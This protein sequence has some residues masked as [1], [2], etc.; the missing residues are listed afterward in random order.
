MFDMAGPSILL[1]EKPFVS[2]YASP[3]LL[4]GTTRRL[5]S[6]AGAGARTTTAGLGVFAADAAQAQESCYDCQ[7]DEFL[8]SSTIL[9]KSEQT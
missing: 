1:P 7:N 4:S 8:H 5:G 9:S 2:R 3:F 6:A